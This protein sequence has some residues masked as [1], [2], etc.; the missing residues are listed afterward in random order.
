MIY[1]GRWGL[2]GYWQLWICYHLQRQRIR[3]L[4]CI[5]VYEEEYFGW[6]DEGCQIPNDENEYP[7]CLDV[8]KVDI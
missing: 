1:A 2:E 5:C 3:S 8:V 6:D 7:S 4:V